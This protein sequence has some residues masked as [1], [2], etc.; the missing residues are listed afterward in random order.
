MTTPSPHDLNRRDLLKGTAAAS[1]S[2]MAST[3]ATRASHAS[4]PPPQAARNLI[5]RENEKPGSRDWQLTR[6]RIN[7]GKYRTSL[8][9]GYCSHQSIAAGEK[10]SAPKSGLQ[11]P[12]ASKLTPVGRATQAKAN[13]EFPVGTRIKYN[14]GSAWV[15]GVI[16]SLEPTVLKFDDNTIIETSYD[17]LKAGAAE[18]IIVKQ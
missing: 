13:G 18:G 8:I 15:A 11:P 4:D 10:A 16:A 5:Q 14:D 6:V 1:L 7:A 17:V 3:L 2:V 9:E 12:E